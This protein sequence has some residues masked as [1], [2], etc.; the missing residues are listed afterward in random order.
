[1]TGKVTEASKRRMAVRDTFVSLT[2]G[3]YFGVEERHGDHEPVISIRIEGSR[4]GIGQALTARI[5]AAID[6]AFA[7]DPDFRVTKRRTA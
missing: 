5:E 3:P 4:E 6:D 2:P 1:M 7:D